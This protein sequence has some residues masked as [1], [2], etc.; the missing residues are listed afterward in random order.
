MIEPAGRFC[1]AHGN[2]SAEHMRMS[3]VDLGKLPRMTGGPRP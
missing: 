2:R 1:D 3:L